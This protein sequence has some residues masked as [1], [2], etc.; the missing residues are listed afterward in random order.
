[1]TQKLNVLFKKYKIK[2]TGVSHFG[3]H[4]GQELEGYLE[5]KIKAIHLFEPQMKYFR[6]LKNISKKF[7]NVFVYKFGLG[8]SNI[9]TNLYSSS[10]YEGVSASVLKP[11]KHKDYFPEVVFDLSDEKIEIIKYDDLN[12]KDVN[13][14]NIDIQGYEL[15]ALKGSVKSL[16][17]VD[18]IFI[19]VSRDEFYEHN[20]KIKELD[21]FLKENS[22]IRVETFW[23]NNKVPQGDALYVKTK[24]VRPLNRLFWVIKNFSDYFEFKFKLIRKKNACIVL[25]KKY[26]K[27]KYYKLMHQS[28]KLY[29]WLRL[30][31]IK[32]LFVGSDSYGTEGIGAMLQWQLWAFALS[33]TYNKNYIFEGFKNVA[34]YRFENLSQEEYS[35]KI[36][37]FLR[38]TDLSVKSPKIFKKLEIYQN[39]EKK[40]DEKFIYNNRRLIQRTF[41]KKINDTFE[42]KTIIKLGSRIPIPTELNQRKINV[43]V[44]LRVTNLDDVDFSEK[45]QYFDRDKNSLKRVNKLINFIEEK[46]PKE[47][48]CFNI[49]IQHENEKLHQLQ[50][51]NN[52]NELKFFIGIDI[53][54]TMSIL[55][56]SNI[57]IGSNSSLSYVCH[58]LSGK[59]SYFDKSFQYK[60]YPNS[61][62]HID[63]EVK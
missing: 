15:E 38:L 60:L 53:F 42:S 40:I 6:E 62:F 44:H 48:L 5:L 14:L 50:L 21:L 27:D 3:A 49:L 63:G 52:R 56:H 30:K 39:N 4:K 10:V 32:N 25:L 29:D 8:S 35:N 1:M 41:D 18:C 59:E 58:L 55:V 28:N 37:K 46:Y 45:R 54:T 51:L 33:K 17:N 36:N 16:S 9:I 24:F 12:I 57:L 11:L 22:F 26:I 43:G 2:I 19:E 13:F 7:D 47:N 34:H 31:L 61:Y 23:I 20:V